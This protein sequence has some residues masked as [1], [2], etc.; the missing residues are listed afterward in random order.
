VPARALS[1]EA[2]DAR[3]ADL[4]REDEAFLAWAREVLAAETIDV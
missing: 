1:A 2:V 4:A 3:R